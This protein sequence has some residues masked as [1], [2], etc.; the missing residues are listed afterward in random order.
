MVVVFRGVIHGTV[1][2]VGDGEGGGAASNYGVGGGEGEKAE[3]IFA[4]F[5]V[6]TN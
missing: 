3:D 6:K 1:E 2:V 4:T 5:M